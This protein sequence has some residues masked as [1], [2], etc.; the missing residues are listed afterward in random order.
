M[1]LCHL[2]LDESKKRTHTEMI[3]IGPGRDYFVCPICDGPAWK[4]WHDSGS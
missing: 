1:R 3:P 2:C 4:V